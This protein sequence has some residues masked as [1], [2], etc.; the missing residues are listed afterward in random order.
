MNPALYIIPILIIVIVV[1]VLMVKLGGGCSNKITL[2]DTDVCLNAN[3]TGLVGQWRGSNPKTVGSKISSVDPKDVAT[4]CLSKCDGNAKCAGV[5]YNSKDKSCSLISVDAGGISNVSGD[6][7]TTSAYLNR[8][9]NTFPFLNNTVK[10]DSPATKEDVSV[11]AP[12]NP[13]TVD[14]TKSKGY[15]FFPGQDINGYDC[16]GDDDDGGDHLQN[17]QSLN[18]C[19]D[20]CNDRADCIGFGAWA[21]ARKD[22]VKENRH[23]AFKCNSSGVKTDDTTGN[24]QL[25]TASPFDKSLYHDGWDGNLFMK[26]VQPVASSS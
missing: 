21:W 17:P 26:I 4:K 8:T 9:M 14:A 23:C 24:R 16:K 7:P 25:N 20:H 6:F 18:T 22:A 5:Q 3:Y 19:F 2:K 13:A 12:L 1:V 11:G 15:Y 10:K